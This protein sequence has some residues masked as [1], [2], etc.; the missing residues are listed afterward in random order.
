L[1]AD[2]W[3]GQHP[4]ALEAGYAFVDALIQDI[5]HLFFATMGTSPA[6]GEGSKDDSTRLVDEQTKKLSWL[7]TLATSEFDGFT[8]FEWTNDPNARVYKS[9]VDPT[10]ADI[11]LEAKEKNVDALS[12]KV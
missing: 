8:K 4:A 1:I 7:K 5:Q 6:E 12:T 11:P 3:E 10:F 2:C 9:T